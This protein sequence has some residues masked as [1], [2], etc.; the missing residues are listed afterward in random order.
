[1][2]RIRL[3]LSIC[4]VSILP[5][6][7]SGQQ[8]TQPIDMHNWVYKKGFD[9]S[10]SPSVRTKEDDKLIKLFTEYY[11]TRSQDP[12]FNELSFYKMLRDK[13]KQFKF[14]LFD[15][16]HVRHDIIVFKVNNDNELLDNFVISTS[17]H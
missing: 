6:C 10:Y 8:N 17:F 1:M 16:K 4:F 2:D 9:P 14:Y 13:D 11:R 15:I 12:K 3:L 5:S 7:T